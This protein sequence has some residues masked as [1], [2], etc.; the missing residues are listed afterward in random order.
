MTMISFECCGSL[1]HRLS[2]VGEDFGYGM[3][4]IN[5]LTAKSFLMDESFKGWGGE[6]SEFY[7]R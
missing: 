6:D 7:N 4:A 5:G 2:W 1:L 3:Y